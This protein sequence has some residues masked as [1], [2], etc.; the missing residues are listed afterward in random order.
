MTMLAMLML[1]LMEIKMEM[2]MEMETC[3]FGQAIL[4]NF[5]SFR[6][7]A[8]TPKTHLAARNPK[9]VNISCH[10]NRDVPSSSLLIS[11]HPL[12]WPRSAAKSPSYCNHHKL[13]PLSPPFSSLSIACSLQSF[14][15]SPIRF[16]AWPE[17]E[18]AVLGKH[19]GG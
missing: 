10:S 11:A 2:E 14:P 5:H 13:S 6:G 1:M 8:C 3:G 7:K 4:A 15:I 17:T 16:I 12:S 9:I 19:R 18:E